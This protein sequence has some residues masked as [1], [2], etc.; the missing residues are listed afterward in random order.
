MSTT[1]K[2]WTRFKLGI[3]WILTEGRSTGS[4]STGQLRKIAGLGVNIMQVYSDAKCYLKGVFNAIEA[5]RSDRDPEGWRID[6]SFDSAELLEYSRDVGL[7]SRWNYYK[8]ITL[9]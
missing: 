7:E 3:S 6:A 9:F 2:K 4:L 8:G 5:F 1:L